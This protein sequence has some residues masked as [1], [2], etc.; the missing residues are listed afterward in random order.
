MA[1][2]PTTHPA[3]P[4]RVVAIATACSV[5]FGAGV[6]VQSRINGELAAELENGYVAA[7]IS[8]GS[9]LVLLSIAMLVAPSGRRG[10]ARIRGEVAQKR[11]PWWF[12][13]GGAA[14]A[15]LVLSQGLTAA[16][17]GVALF[18]VAVVAGQTLSGLLV[19][20]RGIGSNI[21][22][23][24]TVTRLFGS[25]LALAAVVFVVSEQIRSD[26]PLW[27]LVMP[28]VGGLA[29]GWQQAVNGQVRVASRSPLTAAFINFVVGTTALTI[30][31]VV[32]SFWAGWPEVYPSNPWL[33]LGGA[34]GVV[35]I[36][37]A[38]I[39]APITGV[40][41]LGL[42]TTAGQLIASLVLDIV[43]PVA[44]HPLAWT[45]VIGTAVTFVA[46]G[47]AAIPAPAVIRPR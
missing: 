36:A 37:G 9:G 46:V 39:V 7:L 8:F 14:G 43:S 17:V 1:T 28:L 27:V 26:V 34:I 44:A 32:Y 29:I 3:A 15:F 35:F 31:V 6:A 4:T 47:I 33:Y 20:R 10:L 19:D 30:A 2:S 42:G 24:I 22:K 16:V 45:T 18:T 13:F 25:L 11:T 5:V 12:L 38:A 23:P 40:L 21:P 41:L